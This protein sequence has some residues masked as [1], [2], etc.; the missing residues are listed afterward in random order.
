MAL[1]RDI[2]LSA[3]QEAALA[4]LQYALG[5]PPA[6]ALLCG[7]AGVG[8]SLVLSSLAAR[9]A[10]AGVVHAGPASAAELAARVHP[11]RPGMVVLVDDAH[12]ADGADLLRLATSC[13]VVL[14][15]RGRLFTIVARD[16]RLVSRVS[17][18]AVV[19]PFTLDDTRRLVVDGL[20]S[21]GIGEPDPDVVR[22]VHEIAAGIPAT[23]QRLLGMAR[24]VSGVGRR[25][26]VRDIEAIHRRLDIGAA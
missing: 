24:F 11:R 23:I 19:P 25:L 10:D 16:Q 4:R 2:R 6:V 1:H 18:R 12:E 15:G 14:A 8:K 22:T 13:P 20:E 3:A 21:A 5:G 26:S 7:A 9:L 17:L